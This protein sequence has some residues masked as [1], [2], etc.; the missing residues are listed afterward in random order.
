MPRPLY[1]EI[2]RFVSNPDSPY[3]TVGSLCTEAG[4]LLIKHYGLRERYGQEKV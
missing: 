3:K 4:R 1:E 2:E